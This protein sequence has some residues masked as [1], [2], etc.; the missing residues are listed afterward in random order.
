MLF[1]FLSNQERITSWVRPTL[2]GRY[3]VFRK[4]NSLRKKNF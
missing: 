4:K 1:I 2:K 3:I